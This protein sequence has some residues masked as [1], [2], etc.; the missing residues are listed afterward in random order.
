MTLFYW[1]EADYNAAATLSPNNA[2]GKFSLSGNNVFGGIVE[3]IPAQ[4]LDDTIYVVAGYRANGV[5]Y[6]TGV[7]PYSI[8]AFCVSQAASGSDAI[9]PLAASIAVYGYYAKAYFASL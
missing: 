9:K 8:G 7:L 5:S 4:D 2:T 6:C 1:T 3:G